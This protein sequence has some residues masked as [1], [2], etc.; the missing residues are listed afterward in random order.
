MGPWRSW[1]L[2]GVPTKCVVLQGIWREAVGLV[3]EHPAWVP[4][5][6]RVPFLPHDTN[7][8]EGNAVLGRMSC[9]VLAV[10]DMVSL[11]AFKLCRVPIQ[12]VAGV[13]CD[14]SLM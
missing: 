11:Q 2:P 8:K 5:P 4:K 6:P 13:R 7:T 1:S 3:L 10:V 14:L 12:K 9:S